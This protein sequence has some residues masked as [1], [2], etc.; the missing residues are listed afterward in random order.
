[1]IIEPIYSIQ[2]AKERFSWE[3]RGGKERLE[4][5]NIYADIRNII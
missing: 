4:V 5:E 1:M 3:I 2:Y